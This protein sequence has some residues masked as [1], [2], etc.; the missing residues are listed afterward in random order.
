MKINDSNGHLTAIIQPF[1]HTH[2]EADDHIEQMEPTIFKLTRTFRTKSKSATPV[3]RLLIDIVS[4]YHADFTM[5]PAVSYNAN[6]WGDG[7]EPQGYTLGDE[8][9]SFAAHR[10]ALPGGTFSRGQ[11]QGLGLFVDTDE[12]SLPCSCSLF[13]EDGKAVHRLLM[14]E[15]EMPAS[16]LIKGS[17]APG[18]R[19][20]VLLHPDEPLVLTTWI[21]IGEDYQL[22]LD[23]AWKRYYHSITPRFDTDTLWGLGITYAKESLW[24]EDRGY[25]GFSI[26]LNW[27]E[28]NQV[29]A[30]RSTHRYECGWCGQNISFGCSL[31]LDYQKTGNNDSL[32]KALMTLDCWAKAFLPSGLFCVSYDA[33]LGYSHMDNLI[34]DSCN[35][36]GAAENYCRA[37]KL[38]VQCNVD[39]PQYAETARRILERSMSEQ[40]K[41]GAYPSAYRAD[42]SIIT[43]DGSTGC[44]LIPAMLRYSE[45]SGEE[46]YVNSALSAM[47]HYYSS[48]L[49][50]GF[51][52]AGALD[53]YC[54]D[55][56]SA[57]PLLVSAL[58]F[59]N[60]TKDKIW[61][62][63]AKSIAYYLSTWQWHHTCIYPKGTA[64]EA[65]E[66]D[67]FGGTGVSTQHHHIDP[68]ALKY[69]PQL[70]EL[71][72]LTG[73]II[74][75]ERGLAIFNN[76]TIGISDGTL[77]VMGKTR[78]IGS[79][80]EAYM[81]T[82]WSEPYNV[83]QWLVSWPTA[84]RLEVLSDEACVEDLTT[85]V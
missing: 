66:Y 79:Q 68:Y 85:S 69:V 54:I 48:L 78:P 59:F 38:A 6:Q 80:D 47:N 70:L 82:R 10:S 3:C 4:T 49:S 42:G 26:G 27:D 84:F 8:P 83:S 13:I 11:D 39:R 31:L 40:R 45:L 35:L 30:Q 73:E 65:L 33:L 43:Y 5:I 34:I 56:E 55:K 29:W 63:K 18:Y 16:Y 51:T 20:T 52:T 36:G 72:R 44:F 19:D 57:Y 81:H 7:K 22:W 62:E 58:L 64:L 53:T 12:S 14:P 23:T 60:R 32:N 67:T 2:V 74:W 71:A 1:Q 76:A 25:T 50:D 9:W 41:D 21:I 46:S 17:L 28:E 77:V 37:A 15:E 24:A 61:L 75:K